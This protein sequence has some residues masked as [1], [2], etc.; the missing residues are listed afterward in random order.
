MSWDHHIKHFSH[1][2]K[3]ERSLSQNS[4][5]AYVRDV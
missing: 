5:D 2:L 4:I 3:L 1:Y